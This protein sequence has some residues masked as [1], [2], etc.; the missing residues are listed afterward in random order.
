MED[1][2]ENY[3]TSSKQNQAYIG[4]AQYYFEQGQ[5]PQ[6]LEYFDKVDESGLTYDELEKYNFQKGY[7]YFTAKNKKKPQLILIKFPI[8]KNTA[9]KP[10]IIWVY[11]L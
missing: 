9:H 11:G 10:N 5:Y 4:V 8:Q 7:A 3:P 1:F 2:V 6:A